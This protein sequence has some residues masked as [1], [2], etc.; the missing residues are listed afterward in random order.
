M[1]ALKEETVQGFA[2]IYVEKRD[3][4]RVAF[5]ADKIYKALVKASQEVTTMT[6]LLEAKLEGI[7]NKIVAEVIERFPAGVKI[8]E[9]QNIVEH[10][11]LQANEYAIAES[12]ITY[13]TQRDFARSKATDI[14]FTIGKLL[15]KDQAVVNEN[16]NKDSDVFNTQ[17]DLTAGIVGKSIG[18]QML[19]PH[20]ANAHQKGDIHYHDLDYSPY[21]PM[22]NCCLIDFKGMLKNGFKIGNAEVESPK[23]I[24]TATAQISQIIANVASSQYGG[25]SA[26]RIDEVLAPYAEKNYEKH[27]KDAREWVVPE[28]Q[29]EFAWEKTKKDIYDAMQSLEYEINTL[30]TSNGQ[31]PFTSLGFGLGT[32]RFEREIQKAILQIRIKGLGS[33][34]RTAIFPKLIFTLKRGLNL[35]PDSPNYDIKQLALEC[36][37]KRMYPDVL[38]YDKIVELTGSFKVPMGCRSFLQ[39]WKDENGQEVN[40][41]RMNLGVVTVNLPR[42]ALESEG[43][44]EKFWEIFNERMNIAEDA[45]VYRVERTKEATPANAPILYQYGAFGKRL[46]KYDKVD[47]LFKHRRA[48][49]SLG[50]IGLY[51]VATVFYG[52]EWEH[53][54]K[55]KKFTVDIVREMKRRVEEWSDQYDYHFSVYSTPSESL[56]DRFCRLD[57]EK[58]GLVKDITDKEYY[59]NSFHYDVRKN[60]TPFEKLDFEKDYPAAGASGGFIH[61]C[62]YPVLQQNPK[63]LESVWDYAYDRVGYLGTNTPIDHCYKCDFEGDFTPTERGFTCPNCGNSDPKTVDVVKR[64]CGYLGNPQARPMVNGRHKEISARVKH[65]NGSTIKF[66]GHH[67]EK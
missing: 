33:E 53:N 23:S 6:P 50:Y 58:F 41:G 65:M 9:I 28:K 60:P 24:Q 55:A 37:T 36:A 38:S 62:E 27:L 40:S 10:E 39:G 56:T 21:T 49:V 16:A 7:T 29:E 19:P 67:V 22:T 31:T 25:C 43:N 59:T 61:Y 57:T 45:L 3:G 15:N 13:R 63:A 48:T 8:Y 20:V 1:I 47:Q 54:P 14:N 35:E 42:I 11:L 34:H 2:D 51:E 46:G 32:N 18:L 12:Y 26:D 4:R 17:R 64:T 52:G 44:M 66:E 5:D 30:F